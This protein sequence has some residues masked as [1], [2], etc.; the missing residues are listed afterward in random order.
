VVVEGVR[1][2]NAQILGALKGVLQERTVRNEKE[3]GGNLEAA[4]A[5]NPIINAGA[6]KYFVQGRERSQATSA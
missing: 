6:T 2:P 1:K 5:F 4:K 3:R